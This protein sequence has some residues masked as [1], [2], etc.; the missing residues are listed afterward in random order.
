MFNF[1]GLPQELRDAIYEYALVQDTICIQNT[2]IYMSIFDPPCRRTQH[3]VSVWRARSRG[4]LKERF[5]VHI[6]YCMGIQNAKMPN[7]NLFLVSRDVYNQ[8]SRIFYEQNHFV[9]PHDPDWDVSRKGDSNCLDFLQ[10][11]PQHVLNHIRHIRI[12][13]C[14]LFRTQPLSVDSFDDWD[15]LFALLAA[16]VKLRT[17]TLNVSPVS[18]NS[19]FTWWMKHVVHVPGLQRL[20]VSVQA[21]CGSRAT[22]KPEKLQC[23]QY[24]VELLRMVLMPRGKNGKLKI[25]V[26]DGIEADEPSQIVKMT[27]SRE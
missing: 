26:V 7:L 4:R 12:D 18:E 22:L 11:R 15:T 10:D 24:F 16:K 27:A 8:A 3:K 23:C 9:F 17:L 2:E 25:E 20:D 21:W 14:Y 1:M 13:T 19:T 5:D 6:S